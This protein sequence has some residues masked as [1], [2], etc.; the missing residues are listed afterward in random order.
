MAALNSKIF[1]LLLITEKNPLFM[2]HQ[3]TKNLHFFYF[4]RYIFI[5]KLPKLTLKNLNL[6]DS[7]KSQQHKMQMLKFQRINA[8]AGELLHRY[9]PHKIYH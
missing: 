6:K 2:P 1:L 8:A 4:C 3:P 7:V 9:T 5:K